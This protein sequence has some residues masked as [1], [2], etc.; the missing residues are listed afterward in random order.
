M[1]KLASWRFLSQEQKEDELHGAPK[2]S[3][4]SHLLLSPNWPQCPAAQYAQAVYSPW[5]KQGR[6]SKGSR[7][8][9][10]SVGPATSQTQG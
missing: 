2:F 3:S 1:A 4:S 6:G 5:C 10:F 9:K 8:L 7:A